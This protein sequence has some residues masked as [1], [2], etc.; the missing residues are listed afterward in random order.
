[1]EE[2]RCAAV[3]GGAEGTA[4]MPERNGLAEVRLSYEAGLGLTATLA[5]GALPIDLADEASDPLL[6]ALEAAISDQVADIS[7]QTDRDDWRIQR[8]ILGDVGVVRLDGESALVLWRG[9]RAFHLPFTVRAD[10]DGMAIP[11]REVD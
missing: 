11:I 7:A 6:D 2:I 10:L 9:E 5:E 3:R 8:T 1:M 4:D